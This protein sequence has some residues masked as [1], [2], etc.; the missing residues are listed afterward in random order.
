M[1]FTVNAYSNVRN[2]PTAHYAVQYVYE[3]KYPYIIVE[4]PYM[5]E[6]RILCKFTLEHVW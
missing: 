5:Y 4:V 3:Y 2:M 1:Y 6:Y